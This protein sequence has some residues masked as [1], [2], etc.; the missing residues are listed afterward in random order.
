MSV[1]A[2][3]Y[4]AET[5]RQAY[6]PEHKQVKLACV[7]RGTQN[8]SWASATPVGSMELTINNPAA[9][10]F[11][12]IDEDVDYIISIEKVKRYVAGD[13]HAFD[14]DT[15]IKEGHYQFKGCKHC[16]AR[17]EAHVSG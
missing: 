6:N 17:E 1:T 15:S 2:K 13:G 14:E 16:G 9:A 7:T 11:F 4:L 5:T 3:M 10:K 12:D 8:A